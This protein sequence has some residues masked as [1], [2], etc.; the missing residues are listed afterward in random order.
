MPNDEARN[1]AGG[2]HAGGGRADRDHMRRYSRS[3]D[4][5]HDRPAG[6]HWGRPD[7]FTLVELLIVVAIIGILAATVIAEFHRLM[8]MGKAEAIS[9]TV[10]HIRQ[11]IE[12]KAAKREGDIAPSGYPAEVKG[13]WFQLGRLPYHT[14]TNDPMIVETVTAGADQIYPAVKTFDEET[15][16]A[17]NAWYN[18]TNGA[19]CVRVGDTNDDA[20]DLESFNTANNARATTM[21]QTT[22]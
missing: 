10:T 1:R 18:S 7:G 22:G 20:R 16:G 17:E 15:P 4:A 12:L 3:S 9:M 6:R 8:G 19:F 13:E 14:W 2:L 11:I 21:D 5:G